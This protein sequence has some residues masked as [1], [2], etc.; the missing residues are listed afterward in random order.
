MGTINRRIQTELTR[1]KISKALTGKKHTP[2]HKQ[3]I[4]ESLLGKPKT[5]QTIRRMSLAKRNMSDLTK[6]RMSLAKRGKN[7]PLYKVTG[8]ANPR[9]GKKYPKKT[10]QKDL[11]DTS[12]I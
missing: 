2:E 5:K 12:S 10:V 6:Y 4:S 1:Q 9:W 3:R 7:H 11:Y 8:P